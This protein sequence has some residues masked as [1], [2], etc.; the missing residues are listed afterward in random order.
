MS[1][2]WN[3]PE[4]FIFLDVLRRFKSIEKH[5]LFYLIFNITNSKLRSFSH[6]FRNYILKL[7]IEQKIEIVR[8][9]SN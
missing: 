9:I 6:N 8:K 4:L 2:S 1:E 7:L 5:V 3:F